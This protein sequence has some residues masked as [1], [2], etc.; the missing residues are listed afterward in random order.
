MILNKEDDELKWS[1]YSFTDHKI[2]RCD[3][4]LDTKYYSTDIY[5]Y[6]AAERNLIDKQFAESV[7][8]VVLFFDSSQVDT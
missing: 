2:W 6:A 1:E 4:H 7:E 5:F 8:A 3:W